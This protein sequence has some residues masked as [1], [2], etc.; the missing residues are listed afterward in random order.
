MHTYGSCYKAFIFSTLLAAVIAQGQTPQPPPPKTVN[1]PAQDMSV[2]PGDLLNF[3]GTV[4]KTTEVPGN[5][6]IFKALGNN[7]HA[8]SAVTD[9]GD[10]EPAGTPRPAQAGS[11]ADAAVYVLPSAGNTPLSQAEI[12]EKLNHLFTWGPA[13]NQYASYFTL[14]PKPQRMKEANTSQVLNAVDWGSLGSREKTV[15]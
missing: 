14:L 5:R 15:R 6:I 4:T 8:L 13:R 3:D 9:A 12:T 7:I 1:R 2:K 11:P 10:L